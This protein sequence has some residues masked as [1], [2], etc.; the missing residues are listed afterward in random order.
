MALR[1]DRGKVYNAASMEELEPFLD[2]SELRQMLTKQKCGGVCVDGSRCFLGDMSDIF[3]DWVP[4]ALL[5][6][7]FAAMALRPQVTWQVLTKR[8]ERMRQY[9]T[10]R[11]MPG[12][13]ADACRL[14][15]DALRFTSD[16][17]MPWPLPNV[18]LGVSVENQQQAKERLPELLET[19]ATVRFASFEPLLGGI[20]ATRLAVPR[21]H[22]TYLL[23]AFTGKGTTHHGEPF[24]QLP[25]KLDWA[26]VGGE[27]G[28]GA[29]P[30]E[31][32]QIQSLVEQCHLAGVPCFVKQVGS[33]P[34]RTHW[35]GHPLAP[36]QVPADLRNRKGN[37]P[38]EWPEGLRVR[39]F[40]GEVQLLKDQHHDDRDTCPD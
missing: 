6:R 9:L 25:G 31:L 21:V 24:T 27:S 36:I 22:G 19:P 11:Y 20:D 29:R 23:N 38:A 15:F 26:I 3:G 39:Q 17:L 16:N 32:D 40:P 34:T 8:P 35:Y 33:R 13:I 4:D 2:E 12:A 30:C 7:L 28:P 18:W 1:Y 14:S 10:R 37:D 5:Y